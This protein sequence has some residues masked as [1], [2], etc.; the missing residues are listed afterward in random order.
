MTLQEWVAIG[1][2]KGIVE[3]SSC[4]E[5][6]FYDCFRSWFLMKMKSVRKQSLDRIEVTYRKYYADSAFV[7]KNV[8]AIDETAV[9]DFLTCTVVNNGGVSQ[10]EFARIYQIVNNVMRY[11]KDLKI[12]GA[13]LIDW[14]K[15][16][17]YVP[18]SAIVRNDSEEKP[19][20]S[21][22]VARLFHAVIEKKVYF[23]KQN[24]C[25]CV[26]LNFYLGLRIGELASLT[27][28]DIDFENKLLYVSKTET[29]YYERDAE[30][31]R[32][33]A[34]HYHVQDGVKTACSFRCVPLVEEAVY[35]IGLIRTH[36]DVMGYSS[37][38]LAY[39]GGNTILVRSLDRTLRRLCVLVDV[40]YF[41]SH[42]IRKTVATNLHYGGCPTRVI[43]DILGHSEISTTENSYILSVND[44]NCIRNYMKNAL[45]Y[46]L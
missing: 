9:L 2:D 8:S 10:K 39:D 1:V 44:R 3:P 41:N 6:S 25:L 22:H 30:G 31:K 34:M 32:V 24:A 15:I 33:G 4:E 13:R 45:R 21:S 42:V 37:P 7:Q 43:S 23:L 11:C 12:G 35:L 38:Y 36:H 28:N 26:L 40:P 29:K 20:N 27:W 18:A 19:L 46:D 17:N 16:K 5:K 14:E